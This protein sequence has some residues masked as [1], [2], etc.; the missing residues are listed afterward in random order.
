DNTADCDLYHAE[1]AFEKICTAIARSITGRIPDKPGDIPVEDRATVGKGDSGTDVRDMQAMLN[2]T[3]LKPG[4][5]PYGD[6]G[7]LTEDAVTKYQ[8][9]RGLAA[10]GICGQKTW[11]A[12]YDNKPPV[13][14]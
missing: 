9:S 2:N 14:G 4:L 12:L 3:E 13:L 1:G 11:G 6:F 8:R 10:D 5:D 7:N